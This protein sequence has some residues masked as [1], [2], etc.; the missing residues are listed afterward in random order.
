MNDPARS[1]SFDLAA[2]LRRIGYAGELSPSRATLDALH[3]AHAT[4]I[5]FENLDILLGVPI[6][7]DLPSLQAKLVAGRRGGYCFEQNALFASALEHLGFAVTRLAARVRYRSDR[8]LPRTHMA[9]RVDV[10]G[11]RLLADVGFGAE[12]LLL[13]VPLDGVESTQFAWTYRVI[14]EG[15][16]A[17]LLQSRRG[18][19]WEDLYGFTH[20]PQLPV[21]YEIANYYTSTHPASRFTQMLTAQRIAS[22][23]RRFLRDR[24]YVED[25]G[26]TSDTRT[27]DSTELLTVLE[28]KFG[29]V[30]PAG[31]RF[32]RG[33]GAA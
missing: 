7:L 27:I 20:E 6:R 22:D 8:V 25:R 32:D 33:R 16:G 26:A 21:D 9:L 28:Q 14:D 11:A 19:R 18:D 24:E 31:T 2:Y 15:G 29:L 12:G 10:D 5:P 4:S 17:H 3:R 13:P 30:F 23:V 1:V